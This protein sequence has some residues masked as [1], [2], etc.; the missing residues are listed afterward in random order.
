MN[1]Y[2]DNKMDNLEEIDKFLETYNLLRLNQE[3][4]ES[5]NK[6]IISNKIKSVIKKI[7][8]KQKY[9]TRQFHRWI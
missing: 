3:E 2:Y 7:L 9:R 8:N 5:M 4:I 6:P 1:N